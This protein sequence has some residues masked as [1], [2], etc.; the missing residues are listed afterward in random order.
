M[1]DKIKTMKATELIKKL[2]EL[3][4][5]V[6]DADV[7]IDYDCRR[8]TGAHHDEADLEYDYYGWIEIET[9]EEENHR[10]FYETLGWRKCNDDTLNQKLNIRTTESGNKL[11]VVDGYEIS[12]DTLLKLPKED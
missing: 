6:G 4:G 11:L 3:I 5:E 7:I 12:I 10:K 8:I 2:V 1:G 9:E